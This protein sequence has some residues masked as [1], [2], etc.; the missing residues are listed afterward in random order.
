MAT[1]FELENEFRGNIPYLVKYFKKEEVIRRVKESRKDHQ[2]EG[3]PFRLL[4]PLM[5]VVFRSR[6]EVD[7]FN[8]L[9]FN[10]KFEWLRTQAEAVLDYHLENSQLDM[11][12]SILLAPFSKNNENIMTYTTQVDGSIRQ[13]HLPDVLMALEE[14]RLMH[15][16]MNHAMK[17]VFRRAIPMP[18]TKGGKLQRYYYSYE[19][20]I[21]LFAVLPLSTGAAVADPLQYMLDINKLPMNERHVFISLQRNFTRWRE[22]IWPAGEIAPNEKLAELYDKTEAALKEYWKNGFYTAMG[23]EKDEIPEK[24]RYFPTKALENR[25]DLFLPYV[26]VL[27]FLV[28]EQKVQYLHPFKP[29]GDELVIQV[30]FNNHDG[31]PII[32]PYRPGVR[33]LEQGREDAPDG[34]ERVD[35]RGQGDETKREDAFEDKTRLQ[36]SI[37]ISA[38]V[39]LAAIL[40]LPDELLRYPVTQDKLLSRFTEE[41]IS[42]LQDEF[43]DWSSANQILSFYNI[44]PLFS[45]T[46]QYKTAVPDVNPMPKLE[47]L[48]QG[49]SKFA[50]EIRYID[51]EIQAANRKVRPPSGKTLYPKSLAK[52]VQEMAIL[53]LGKEIRNSRLMERDPKKIAARKLDRAKF[54]GRIQDWRRDNLREQYFDLWMS[55]IDSLYPHFGQSTFSTRK[56]GIFAEH[57]ILKVEE[58]CGM[59]I[60]FEEFFDRTENTNVN[61]NYYMKVSQADC[62]RPNAFGNGQSDPRD[63]PETGSGESP[64]EGANTPKPGPPSGKH[65]YDND[66]DNDGGLFKL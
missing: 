44:S 61:G 35:V 55:P 4:K 41:T 24:R 17:Y 9:D 51:D 30:T 39:F 64:S 15:R 25:R 63:I 46:D 21:D 45:A 19:P 42:L 52:Y 8:E 26:S 31:D 6:G 23:I 1:A 57:H 7:R 53:A 38:R 34:A 12:P 32:G 66:G 16:H 58:N 50:V 14:A 65:N 2:A 20:M 56:T 27:P 40:S 28:D 59:E 48:Y 3:F 60:K 36:T 62:D 22:E 47:E 49:E 37:F 10:E 11:V 33:G 18:G 54:N 43:S 5:E 13:D 29:K